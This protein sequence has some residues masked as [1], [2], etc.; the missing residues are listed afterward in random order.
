MGAASSLDL[1][2]RVSAV[3]PR[4]GKPVAAGSLKLYRGSVAGFRDPGCRDRFEKAAGMFETAIAAR[5]GGG[6]I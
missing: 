1:A 2:D 5:I 4:S 3:R 6:M